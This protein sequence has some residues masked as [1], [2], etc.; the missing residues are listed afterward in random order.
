MAGS[1]GLTENVVLDQTF[2]DVDLVGRPLTLG[3][4]TAIN[5]TGFTYT[6]TTNTYA[7]Y[8]AWGDDA[9]NFD[10]RSR[11]PGG[12]VFRKFIRASRSETPC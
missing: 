4:N 2:N 9:Y 5:S 12:Q 1:S 11:H 6:T 7:P 8:L 3:F 10:P